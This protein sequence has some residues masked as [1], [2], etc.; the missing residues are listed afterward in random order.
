MLNQELHYEIKLPENLQDENIKIRFFLDGNRVSEESLTYSKQFEQTGNFEL[1]AKVQRNECEQTLNTSI[2]IY[3]KNLLYLGAELEFL[4]FGFEE[5]LNKAGYLFSKI[6]TT[7]NEK[8]AD[9]EHLA[10]NSAQIIIINDK[11]IQNYLEKYI[12]LKRSNPSPTAKNLVIATSANPILLRRSFAQYA[13]DLENDIITIIKPTNLINLISDLSLGKDFTKQEYCTQFSW[14]FK[15][16]PKRMF[17]SYFVDEL[18]KTGFPIQILGLLLTLSVA[19]VIISFL[20]QI[21]GLGVFGVY[22][23][24][25][26]A[27]CASIAGLKVTFF[28]FGI[29]LLASLVIKTI[30]R[31]FYLLQSCKVSLLIS[32]F[33]LFFLAGSRIS[34][35]FE[36]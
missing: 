22:S 26:L 16:S 5:E 13:E 24:S 6:F 15:N 29:A 4:H 11:K 28:I 7:E 25:L 23:P 17:L 1:L 34:T 30:T 31:R 14:D 19:A 18:L 10:F 21:I 32:F 2:A 8:K 20:R 33:L 36:L 3:E 27:L 12:A 9:E 35:K